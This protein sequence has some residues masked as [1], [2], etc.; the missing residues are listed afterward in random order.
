MKVMEQVRR[1]SPIVCV[2]ARIY[3]FDRVQ[4]ANSLNWNL[5]LLLRNL[6]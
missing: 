4:E 3:V 6:W 1:I 2:C 5:R